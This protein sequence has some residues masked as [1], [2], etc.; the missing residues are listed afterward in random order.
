[1]GCFAAFGLLA[2]LK[3]GVPDIEALRAEI[4]A[5]FFRYLAILLL[6]N[7]CVWAGWWGVFS[8]AGEP[9]W[10]ALIPIYNYAVLFRIAGIPEWY[11]I[12]ILIPYLGAIAGMVL[13]IMVALEL[14]KRFNLGAG[15]T[16]GLVLLAP[17]F[18][19]ILGFGSAECDDGH[20]PR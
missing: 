6:L 5:L 11:V 19:P 15:F 9:G 10:A 2:Q 1:M 20:G 17:I 18:Y 12:L 16:L 7:L 4:E 13:L 14:S 3:Q 8:K